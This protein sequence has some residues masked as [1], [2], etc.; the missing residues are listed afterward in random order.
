MFRSNV[1]D[2]CTIHVYANTQIMIHLEKQ[3]SFGY[4]IHLCFLNNNDVMN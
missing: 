2:M 3:D 1:F 4:L